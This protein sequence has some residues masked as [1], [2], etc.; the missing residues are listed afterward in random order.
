MK[1]TQITLIAL[2]AVCIAACSSSKKATTSTAISSPAST[3]PLVFAKPAEAL[4]VPGSEELTAIQVQYKDATLALLMQGHAIYTQGAC[5]NCHGANNIY[6]YGEAQ[7]KDIVE[8]MA[9]RAMLSD[10]EKDAV[11]KYVLAIK[12]T[13]PSEK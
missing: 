3:S 12:A 10:V 6:Q 1:A 8:D 9:H 4:F 7:W 5:M 2:I 11:Y 13:Q